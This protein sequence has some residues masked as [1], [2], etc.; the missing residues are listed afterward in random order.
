[1]RDIECHTCY[2][3]NLVDPKESFKCGACGSMNE[4]EQEEQT[5]EQE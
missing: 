1:M 3:E 4:V 2:T 5:E